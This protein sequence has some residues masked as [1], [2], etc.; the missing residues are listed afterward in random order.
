MLE[1]AKLILE[2]G[3]IFQGLAAG[4]NGVAFGEVVFNTSISG[5]QEILTDPSYA[6]Q[7][8]TLTYPHIGNVGVNAN[9]EESGGVQAAGLVIRDLPAVTSNWRAT[10]PFSEYLS[11]NKMI[12]IT[13]L[14]T[15]ALTQH[16]RKNGALRGAIVCGEHSQEQ[17][18]T[19]IRALPSLAGQDLAQKVTTKE[20]YTWT[21]AAWLLEKQ[22]TPVSTHKVA[23]VDFG[24]KRS[25]L[26]N[27]VS[28]GA[29]VIV[30]PAKTTFS[31][32]QAL[33]VHGVLL[34]NGPGDPQPCDYAIELAQQLI[35]HKIPV[36]GIC[37]GFQILS[38]AIGAQTTKMKF[39]HHGGNHPVKDLLSGKVLIT[40]QNHGFCVDGDSLPESVKVSHVSLFDGTLQGWRHTKL[41][42][43]GFQGHP[44][45]G[46]G[47]SDALGLFELFMQ[48]C[49]AAIRQ[50]TGA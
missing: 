19:D 3:T 20:S 25:I 28:N 43:M 34:S 18:L 10:Q 26:R 36:F 2:D 31:E 30:V 12:A 33:N 21:E 40:S 4:A 17:V 37:L 1:P 23:V 16:I 27:L 49:R 11:D 44:E 29:E 13:E 45:A 8:V 15:R 46:P 42:V 32:I 47:P 7:I 9:D 35:E 48:D 39:G 24:V 22:D 38:L 5:Y 50:K 41:P 14:D 6:G